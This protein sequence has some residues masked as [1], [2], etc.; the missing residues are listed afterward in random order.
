MNWMYPL[1]LV[2]MFACDEDVPVEDVDKGKSKPVKTVG[3]A[4][5]TSVFAR[6]EQ[7]ETWTFHVTVEH[8]D[9]NWDDFADGWDVVLPDGVTLQPDPFHQFTKYIRH[10]H[11]NEQPFTRTQKA[12]EI[13]E[14]VDQV[15][16]RAHDKKD[17][18][19][20]KEVEVDL[21]VRFG[22]QFSVKRTP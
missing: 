10:P 19:G 17:G 16:V 6:Q 4:D 15:V 11:V 5:V 8:E 14:G 9:V 21:N 2:G 13:P 22:E 3:N 1:I 18:W 20:G 7:D 12:I